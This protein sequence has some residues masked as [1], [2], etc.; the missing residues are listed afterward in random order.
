MWIAAGPGKLLAVLCKDYGGKG[1]LWVAGGGEFGR[2][3]LP[4]AAQSS[5]GGGAERGVGLV[6]GGS[7]G[8]GGE[9][10]GEAQG[11]GQFKGGPRASWGSVPWRRGAILGEKGGVRCAAGEMDMAGGATA[12]A[13]AGF[14]GVAESGADRWARGRGE[15]EG[16]ALGRAGRRGLRALARGRPGSGLNGGRGAASGPRA[17]MG[18]ATA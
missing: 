18:E 5:P 16:D 17:G 13:A 1:G 4:A 11:R 3:S 15:G 12:S 8:G 9:E 14:A 2:R 7:G 10:M 6:L